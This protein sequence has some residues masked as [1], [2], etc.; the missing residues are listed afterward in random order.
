MICLHRQ[1]VEGGDRPPGRWCIACG[2]KIFR[3]RRAV[4]EILSR[5]DRER[6]FARQYTAVERELCKKRDP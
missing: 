1:Y 2:K 4:D 5:K 6:S 3:H